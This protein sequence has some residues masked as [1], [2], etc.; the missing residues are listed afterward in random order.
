MIQSRK[1]N[2]E[3]RDESQESRQQTF[4]DNWTMEELARSEKKRLEQEIDKTMEMLMKKHKQ[5][6]DKIKNDLHRQ[7]KKEIDEITNA[8]NNKHDKEITRMQKELQ[9]MRSKKELAEQKLEDARKCLGGLSDTEK[10]VASNNAFM[11]CCICMERPSNSFLMPC[12]HTFCMVCAEAQ[13]SELN[14]KCSVCR[15]TI[16]CVRQIH[17]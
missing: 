16:E 14:G 11:C 6:V 4:R 7:H 5:E 12:G 2:V 17:S 3:N 15:Q 9:D 8:K 10:V 13:E 1:D